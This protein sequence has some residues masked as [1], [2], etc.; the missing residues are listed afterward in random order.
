MTSMQH[1]TDAVLRETA[2][3]WGLKP[4]TAM[5]REAS[6]DA[7]G[8]ETSAGELVQGR[9]RDTLAHSVCSY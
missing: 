4:G 5:D 7:R 6:N 2:R 1:A 9:R 8:F 3:Y